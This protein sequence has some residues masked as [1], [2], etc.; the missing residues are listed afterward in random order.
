[1]QRLT[2]LILALLLSG[3]AAG[4][5]PEQ[6]SFRNVLVVA[7]DP[8]SLLS[9]KEQLSAGKLPALK[10][11]DRNGSIARL[12]C[13]KCSE[14]LNE[15]WSQ[16]LSG[17]NQGKLE[18]ATPERIAIPEDLSLFRRM[19]VA[20]PGAAL[21]TFA[22]TPLKA[23]SLANIVVNAGGASAAEKLPGALA[24]KPGQPFVG[25]VDLR[26]GGKNIKDTDLLLGKV[27]A[28]LQNVNSV[29]STLLFVV[30][31]T[32]KKDLGFVVVNAP[33]LREQGNYR[34][35]APTALSFFGVDT[36]NLQPGIH[37]ETL[38]LLESEKRK[39]NSATGQALRLGYFFGVRTA[40]ILRASVN[41]YFDRAGLEIDLLT[42]YLDDNSYL[43]MPK[44]FEEIRS[45]K[46]ARLG[47]VTGDQLIKAML[48]GKF[49]AATIGE[50]SF[51]KAVAEGA[52]IVAIAELSHDRQDGAARAILLRKELKIRSAAD[53]KGKTLVAKRSAGLDNVLLKEFLRHE[54]LTP[55]VDVTIKENYRDDRMAP[56]FRAGKI[57][58]GLYHLS[59]ARKM[60]EG[61]LGEI[62]SRFDWLDPEATQALLV[63]P[64]KEYKKKQ[65]EL[66]AFL[67][68]L[69]RL[70]TY[71]SGLSKEERLQFRRIKGMQLDDEGVPG[72]SLPTMKALPL[73]RPEKLRKMNELLKTHKVVPRLLDLDDSLDNS[74]VKSAADKAKEK[75]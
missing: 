45:R 51:L 1:L 70:Q 41:G 3:A 57:D 36:K 30:S 58:G 5:P 25:F 6:A 56:D 4:A 15:R 19:A 24:K 52:P 2:L 53:L 31:A 65:K 13:V 8:F 62:Y 39:K 10:E 21:H 33:H 26:G 38:R 68:A 20:K 37:G 35:I 73:V 67:S 59:E 27:Q 44:T 49:D 34:D 22:I 61:G 9:V 75:Q 48:Q 17:M 40:M 16:I 64:K 55:G 14:D 29:Q 28:A 42:R 47:K 54:G 11:L 50:T 72:L 7:I 71:E 46:V 12:K 69:M 66:I 43:P 63:V 23:E 32:P 60:V 18:K 74:L